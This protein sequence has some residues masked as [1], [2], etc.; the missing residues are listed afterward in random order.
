MLHSGQ[1]HKSQKK[2]NSGWKQGFRSITKRLK[3]IHVL[4][5][6]SWP[7]VGLKLA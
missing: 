6:R 5:R 1:D 3:P 2:E 7:K 4:K